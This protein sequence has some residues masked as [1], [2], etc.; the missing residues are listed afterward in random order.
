[1]MA[2]TERKDM[3]VL[4]EQAVSVCTRLSVCGGVWIH[5]WTSERIASTEEPELVDLEATA[6]Q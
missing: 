3:T 4:I 2:E 5:T 1:M 6:P